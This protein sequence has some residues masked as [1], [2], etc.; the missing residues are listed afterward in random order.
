MID[1]LWEETKEADRKCEMPVRWGFGCSLPATNPCGAPACIVMHCCGETDWYL[2]RPACKGHFICQPCF[3]E[4]YDAE[5][6]GAK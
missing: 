3:D 6:G 4:M 1:Q 5:Y 2:A